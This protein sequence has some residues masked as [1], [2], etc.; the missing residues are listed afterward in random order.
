MDS[1]ALAAAAAAV[2]ELAS[3]AAA[4]GLA[5]SG[6][7]SVA[8][9]LVANDG[10][11][12]G[13]AVRAAS[14]ASVAAEAPAPAGAL[15]AAAAAAADADDADGWAPPAV[16]TQLGDRLALQ[17]S[18]AR[19]TAAAGVGAAAATPPAAAAAGLPLGGFDW[20][21]F[22]VDHTL[23]AYRQGAV[24]EALFRATSRH[25]IQHG[26]HNARSYSVKDS[27]RGSL[28]LGT[29]LVGN[30]L[31][32]YRALLAAHLLIDSRLD[33]LS[34]GGGGGE[35]APGGSAAAAPLLSPGQSRYAPTAVGAAGHVATAL[36]PPPT[37]LS[38]L[39]SGALVDFRSILAAAE[40]PNLSATRAGSLPFWGHLARTGAVLDF[41]RG[42][43]LW[44]DDS[45]CVVRGVHG[46]RVLTER[47]LRRIYGPTKGPLPLPGVP[48]A[49]VDSVSGGTPASPSSATSTPTSPTSTSGA[50]HLSPH[51][52]ASLREAK[53]KLHAVM[54]MSMPVGPFSGPASGG[55]SSSASGAS[56]TAA[57]SHG[58]SGASP[59]AAPGAGYGVVLSGFDESLPPLFALL[60][61]RYDGWLRGDPARRRASEGDMIAEFQREQ[62][63]YEAAMAA[64]AAAAEGGHLPTVEEA[65]DEDGADADASLG[66]RS[67]VGWS[68]ASIG[69]RRALSRAGG[70][71]AS[72]RAA[73]TSAADTEGV[74]TGIDDDDD[75]DDDDDGNGGSGAPSRSR[76]A[77]DAGGAHPSTGSS[78]RG[79]DGTP[80]G[81]GDADSDDDGDGA[82]STSGY[83]DY[84]AFLRDAMRPTH[85]AAK[86]ALAAG[87]PPR[88]PGSPPVDYAF[89]AEALQAAHRFVYSGYCSYGF[90]S[91][92][93]SLDAYVDKRPATKSWLAGLRKLPLPQLPAAAGVAATASGAVAVD[94]TTGDGAAADSG[95]GLAA[96]ASLALTGRARRLRTFIVTNASWEHLAPA[97]RHAYGPDWL[98]LFDAVFIE[99]RK[100]TLFGA[101]AAPA[102]GVGEGSGAG[103]DD[104]DSEGHTNS[105]SSSGGS[106]AR[107]MIGGA[108]GGK[109]AAPTSAP[110]RPIDPKTGRMM[111]PVSGRPVL[112]T[113]ADPAAAGGQA[114]VADLSASKVWTGGSL[115]DIVATLREAAAAPVPLDGSAP[116]S[117][118]AAGVRVCYV[119]DH[120]Q[121]DVAGPATS[122]G[123]TT[124]AV[125]PA[126]EA[127][128]AVAGAEG[129]AAQLVAPATG[130]LVDPRLLGGPAPTSAR[131]RSHAELPHA[132]ADAEYHLLS[133]GSGPHWARPSLQAAVALRHAALAVPSVEWLARA[134]LPRVTAALAAADKAG[135]SKL[136][137]APPRAAAGGGSSGASASPTASKGAGAVLA[138]G[139]GVP[140]AARRALLRAALALRVAP[141][142][143]LQLHRVPAPASVLRTALVAARLPTSGNPLARLLELEPA[144]AGAG[145]GAPDARPQLQSVASAPAMPPLIDSTIG[146]GV[147]RMVAHDDA[148]GRVEE[149]PAGGCGCF[150][151]KG[152]AAKAAGGGSDNAPPAS[153]ASSTHGSVR[154]A[155]ADSSPPLAE[156]ALWLQQTAVAAGVAPDGGTP[157][158]CRAAGSVWPASTPL[159]ELAATGCWFVP[160]R[161]RAAGPD[162]SARSGGDGWELVCGGLRDDAGLS[163]SAA[164]A[165]PVWPVLA[166]AM[167]AA[168]TAEGDR[169]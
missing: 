76:A 137:L 33:A 70:S 153:A 41:H 71:G 6:L 28:L 165:P 29:N 11:A 84:D 12:L 24:N 61:A 56:S 3:P 161:A 69:R 148:V 86:A 48:A 13:P 1:P 40:D 122:A 91:L 146:T 80:S 132:V 123:W 44:V 31:A 119:G 82:A 162:G 23:L 99:A 83:D 15:L 7:G 160:R 144:A 36:P 10:T 73:A 47:Q 85:A 166:A 4:A 167:V 55:G 154:S 142:E 156:A 113:V 49:A 34:G 53:A 129:S 65:D 107:G 60:V 74:H 138:S 81:G 42:N 95:A 88:R 5:A 150:G 152:K 112:R 110:L 140:N 114:L 19:Y 111:A 92:W 118:A 127:L 157:P 46:R 108:R 78:S 75:D 20:L 72:P 169:A 120:M 104:D 35:G 58:A 151:G 155:A 45:G 62:D 149:V 130:A 67:T 128:A 105:S 98:D 115:A 22:D 159:A 158:S 9:A 8:G 39:S 50:H 17:Q 97:L 52:D 133:L 93:N 66:R 77:S 90:S 126:L 27:A 131:A 141:S 117:S 145:A 2:L 57:G 32:Q 116:P 38:R 164:T 103:F 109:A 14:R 134:T 63:E 124:V 43:V 64:V 68:H 136:P 125:L 30:R 26:G 79:R 163:A 101:A 121:Q 21:G 87:R 16:L 18:L 96:A 135:A 139:A 25:L 143:L 37:A 94:V 100:R 51:E 147:S 54:A 168:A 59:A 106:G 102:A 89:L